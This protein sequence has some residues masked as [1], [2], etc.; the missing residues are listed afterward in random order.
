MR[1]KENKEKKYCKVESKNY[2][3]LSYGSSVCKESRFK[4]WIEYVGVKLSWKTPIT[5]KDYWCNTS[6]GFSKN[7]GDD[8]FK[9]KQKFFL[10]LV[11][12]ADISEEYLLLNGVSVSSN[13]FV[14]W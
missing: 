2:E 12:V 5:I 1:L 8:P 14:I 3:D 7:V 13:H 9:L 4:W 10:S 11:N 6:V